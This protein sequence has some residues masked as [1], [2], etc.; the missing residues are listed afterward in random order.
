VEPEDVERVNRR[1][2]SVNDLDDVERR[3]FILRLISHLGVKGQTAVRLFQVLAQQLS[4]VTTEDDAEG[5]RDAVLQIAAAASFADERALLELTRAL[6][7]DEHTRPAELATALCCF[8]Q[9]LDSRGD[10]ISRGRSVL[11]RHLGDAPSCKPLVE[12]L[13]AAA[14]E[15]R[16]GSLTPVD[17]QRGALS[18]EHGSGYGD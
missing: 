13:A 1:L 17:F 7:V 16:H 11:T 6:P 15:I 14:D 2:K 4:A 3:D 8:L 18:G 10:S 5:L 12:A 9:A